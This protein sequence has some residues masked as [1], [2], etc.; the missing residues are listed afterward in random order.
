M[1]NTPLTLHAGISSLMKSM[2]T[3]VLIA[4]S[5]LCARAKG[6]AAKAGV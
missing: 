6:V 1:N 4:N 3:K 2:N 5:V